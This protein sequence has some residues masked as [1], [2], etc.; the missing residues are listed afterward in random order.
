MSTIRTLSE[1]VERVRGRKGIVAVAV[2]EDVVVLKAIKAAVNEEI[3]EFL[4]FGNQRKI[5]EIAGEIGLDHGYKIVGTQ[6]NADAVKK[7]VEAVA[8]GEASLLMKGKVKTGDLLSVYLKEEYGLRTGRTMNL[9]SVFEIPEYSRL[10]VVTD[11]GMVIAP[12]LKQKADSIVNASIVARALGIEPPKVAVLGAIEVVNEKM[13][14]TLD[15]AILSKM[16]QRGQLGKVVVDG[17]FA[18]DNAVSIEAAKHKGIESPVAGQAD[19]L[20][21]PDIE[22]GNIF[23]KAMVFLG[24][25]EVASSIVGGK[26]PIILTSRADSDRTKLY[27]IALNVL[28]SEG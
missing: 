27:S 3:A 10:L 25:A 6:S 14:A 13:P 5:E 16:S 22:A 2:A 20:I 19:I 15:A 11:A 26:I 7:A 8:K 18:L 28:L 1:I 17:P 21:M 23:Y 24:K 12:D 9:V 4:L